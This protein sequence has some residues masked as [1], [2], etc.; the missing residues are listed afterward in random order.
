MAKKQ[1][2]EHRKQET[3]CLVIFYHVLLRFLPALTYIVIES[4]NKSDITNFVTCWMVIHCET[5]VTKSLAQKYFLGLLR[6]HDPRIFEIFEQ[7]FKQ[8]N[9]DLIYYDKHGIKVF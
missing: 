5:T 4:V 7:F 8:S 3:V 2:I 6:E 1:K 9:R